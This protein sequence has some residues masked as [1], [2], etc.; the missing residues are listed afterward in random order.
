MKLTIVCNFWGS[1]CICRSCRDNKPAITS[2]KIIL[3]SLSPLWIA[4][5]KHFK[6]CMTKWRQNVFVPKESLHSAVGCLKPI[7]TLLSRGYKESAWKRGASWLSRFNFK[8]VSL[9]SV[10]DALNTT[11]SVSILYAIG[12]LEFDLL[13]CCMTCWAISYLNRHECSH[14]VSSAELPESS[15]CELDVL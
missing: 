9:L 12:R 7:I 6:S 10:S 15:A 1:L 8:G 2:N 5:Q 14:L 3:F 4:Q 11:Y 13:A